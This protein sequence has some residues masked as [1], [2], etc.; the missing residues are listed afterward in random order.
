MPE[1]ERGNM[2]RALLDRRLARLRDAAAGATSHRDPAATE[3]HGRRRRRA[4]QAGAAAL[5]GVAVVAA[6]AVLAGRPPEPAD[7][8]PAPVA[9]PP[10]TEEPATQLADGRD[11]E[12]AQP[13]A[14]RLA[15]VGG[16]EFQV[17]DGWAVADPAGCPGLAGQPELVV[18]A[19]GDQALPAGCGP[20][21]WPFALLELRPER[22]LPGAAARTVAGRRVLV[23]PGP[24]RPGQLPV[25]PGW[26][27]TTAVLP[28]GA[29]NEQGGAV[30]LQVVEPGPA[31]PLFERILGSAS[32]G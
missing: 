3:R 8:Q 29:G 22:D 31:T 18:A 4:R 20:S 5:A 23:R 16:L 26:T 19:P 30:W 12:L 21:E 9:A 15:A 27:V 28:G 24:A 32:S 2:P 25:P 10:T 14:G 6:V 17:P 11:A 13:L 1:S 7:V